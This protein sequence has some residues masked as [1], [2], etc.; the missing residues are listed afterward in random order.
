ML[1]LLRSAFRSRKLLL[2]CEITKLGMT[3]MGLG[4]VKTRLDHAAHIVGRFE[5]RFERNLAS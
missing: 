3:A 1:Q 5:L 2:R 4:R